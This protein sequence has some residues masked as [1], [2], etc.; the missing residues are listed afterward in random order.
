M[1]EIRIDYEGQ[2]R[3]GAKHMP[4]Q[5]KMETDAPTDNHGRGESFSPTDLLAT[6]LGTCMA[7]V[8]GIVGKNKDV[9]LR[10]MRVVV[11]KEMSDDLP[12]RIAKLN[13]EVFMPIPEDHPERRVLQS[14]ALSCPVQ[15]SIHPDIEVP[16]EWHWQEIGSA[17]A[18]PPQL[19]ASSTVMNPSRISRTSGN[20]VS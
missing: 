19:Q 8:M 7:T 2:L 14:A 3:C 10:G 20:C 15:H 11:G 9:E 5:R 12:R 16:I 18:S 4:S 17:L 1:V 13:V 6:G